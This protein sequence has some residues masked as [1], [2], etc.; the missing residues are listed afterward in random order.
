[1]RKVLLLVLLCE[2]IVTITTLAQQPTFTP[3]DPKVYEP[4]LGSYELPSGELIVIGRSVRR[5]F[6]YEPA[7]GQ[8]RGLAPASDQSSAELTW[9]AGPSLAVFSPPAFTITFTKNKAGEISG[10]VLSKEGAR[11]QTAKRARSYKEEETVFRNGEITLGGKLLVPSTKGPHPAAIF[12]HGSGPQ[13]RNGELSQ[14][15]LM[16][17]HFAR[18][19]VA[20]LIYDKRGYGA[21]TGNWA[22][23]SFGDFAGDALAGLKLL[24]SRADIA[25]SKIGF[26]GVSQAGWVMTTATSMLK[27]IAFI[28]SISAGGS[29]YTPAQQNNYN[30]ATEMRANDFSEDDITRVLRCNDLL[31]ELVRAGERSNGGPLDAAIQEAL[32]QNAKLKDWLPPSST[33]ID[34]KKRDHWFLALDIDFDPVPLWEKFEGPVQAI[35]GELDNSTPAKDVVPILG[36][37]LARRQRT[38]YAITV[39]ARANHNIFEAE[40]G[41]DTEL[42]RLTRLKP[43]FMPTMIDWLRTRLDLKDRPSP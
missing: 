42:P 20:S 33:E 3:L 13:D 24:Q 26:V 39:F 1:M 22:T 9:S 19:G 17:D 4:Y 11:E 37:A 16:A 43:E 10:L 12:L 35:F 15:R 34:W 40:T 41:S 38:D 29:G 30:T 14:I 7:T 32:Q 2:S 21:S 8:I 31:Y 27:D 23:A 6:F 36:A 5:L 28:I 18:H 25:P